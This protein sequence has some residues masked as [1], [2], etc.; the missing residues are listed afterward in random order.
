[1]NP[2]ENYHEQYDWLQNHC[3]A[4]I[5]SPVS[6]YVS[7]LRHHLQSLK[8]LLQYKFLRSLMQ[9]LRVTSTAVNNMMTRVSLLSSK[10][11]E[12][13]ASQ[14]KLAR[15]KAT[16]TEESKSPYNTETKCDNENVRQLQHRARPKM[17]ERSLQWAWKTSVN[18]IYLEYLLQM[19]DI[20]CIQEYWLFNFAKEVI[21][22]FLFFIHHVGHLFIPSYWTLF[23]CSLLQ[24]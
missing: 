1:M 16:D 11:R 4:S 10:L 20:I 22:A 2:E 13:V 3:S 8:H 14:Q 5:Y 23:L 19:F 21:G 9:Q 7:T 18:K 15:Q 17:N 6:T 24:E 12:G